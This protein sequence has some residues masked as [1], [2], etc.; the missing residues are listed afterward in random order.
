MPI[1][2]PWS[3]QDAELWFG[4]AMTTSAGLWFLI[5][6]FFAVKDYDKWRS[7]IE[8]PVSRAIYAI[9]V[10]IAGTGFGMLFF[11]PLLAMALTA[12][13]LGG[14]ILLLVWSLRSLGRLVLTKAG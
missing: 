10:V 6:L 5:G 1:E 8:G 12:L 9:V 14:P 3:P 2:V 4:Y 7:G 11:L 13:A